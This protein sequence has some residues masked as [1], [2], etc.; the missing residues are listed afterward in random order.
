M[1]AIQTLPKQWR[2]MQRSSIEELTF[3]ALSGQL[4]WL[5]STCPKHG[6]C[7][8]LDRDGVGMEAVPES[9]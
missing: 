7:V 2:E 8:G 6:R 1:K 4:G 5:I 9:R 3:G